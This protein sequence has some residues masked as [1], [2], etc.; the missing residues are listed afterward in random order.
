[1]TVP[2]SYKQFAQKVSA[3]PIAWRR[4]K[5]VAAI[6]IPEMNG[7]EQ[8]ANRAGARQPS[9]SRNLALHGSHGSILAEHTQNRITDRGMLGTYGI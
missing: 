4:N 7:R 2:F 5:T 1:M 9:L 3:A 6:M 8:R